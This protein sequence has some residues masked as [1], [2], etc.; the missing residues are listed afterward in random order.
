[1][2]NFIQVPKQEDCTPATVRVG[3]D[4]VT[5]LAGK[6]VQVWCRVPQN[7]DTSDLLVL[8][9]PV[10]DNVAL[11]HLS[12]GEGLLKVNNT[13]RPYVK[14]PISNHSKDDVF[15][16]RRT[17]L[18]TIQHVTKLIETKAP[19]TTSHQPNPVTRS[20]TG[21][22]KTT[23]PSDPLTE[24][25]LPPVDLSHLSPD[26][27][28]SVEKVLVEECRAFSRDSG[29][30]GCI[31][32]LQMEIR[33]KDDTPV[34]RAYASIPKPLYREVKEYIQELLGK[35]WVVKSRSPYAAPVIC[36]RK[37]DGSLRLCIDYRLLNSKTVPDKHP[38][39]RIQDPAVKPQKGNRRSKERS[40]APDHFQNPE[41]RDSEDGAPFYW[42]CT[43]VDYSRIE[44]PYTPEQERCIDAEEEQMT[45]MENVE[46]TNL[47]LSDDGQGE[48]QFH[49]E[50]GSQESSPQ[51]A[52]SFGPE[53]DSSLEESPRWRQLTRQRRP[54]RI[55]TYPSLGQPDY[56]PC[57]TVNTVNVQP[58]MY[59]LLYYHAVY[60]QPPYPTTN[61]Y[62]QIPYTVPCFW[63]EGH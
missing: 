37:R 3:K 61:P 58:A 31:P 43:P 10:E 16:P 39:P 14:I 56:C 63:N 44:H 26:Q 17:A 8:Y 49:E 35:G 62:L 25:W 27:Q 21:I 48:P 45:N 42:C 32:S 29:D 15:L 24:L 19:A 52:S 36:V 7:F 18:G 2:V 4:N 40:T 12:I 11:R 20:A 28:K 23:P 55:F 33:L 1:M 38:L 13:P 34:Q 47:P 57:P 50:M 41:I 5:I 59:P 22:D 51:P 46:G 30:I 60:P 54:T 9:E 6:A 53:Q